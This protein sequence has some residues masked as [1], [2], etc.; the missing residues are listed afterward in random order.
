MSHRLDKDADTKYHD[1]KEPRTS[2]SRSTGDY[3]RRQTGRSD[4]QSEDAEAMWNIARESENNK[5][6]GSFSDEWQS[7]ENIKEE[8][9]KMKAPQ[10][11]RRT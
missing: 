7:V 11:G 6:R 3:E 9:E 10:A 8:S 2:R 5:N 1:Y 4:V